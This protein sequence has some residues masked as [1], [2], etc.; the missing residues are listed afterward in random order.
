MAI[1]SNF[2]AIKPSLLLDF[3]NTKQLDPR[4]T[5]TRASTATFYDGVTTAKAEQNLLTYSQD[6]ANA[7]WTLYYGT[8]T[9]NS[10]VAPDGTTTA[11]TL[12]PSGQYASVVQN[13]ATIVGQQY[14]YS[15]WVKRATGS[16]VMSLYNAATGTDILSFTPTASWVRYSATFTATTALDA[17]YIQDRNASGWTAW[18]MWGAQLEQR[19][20]VTA[21]TATT[22]QAITNFIPVLQTAASGVARFDNNP[23]TGESLGLLI[24]ESR[25]NLVT[26]SEQ[27]DNAA[28]TKTNVSITANTIIAPDGT[29]TGDKIVENTSTTNHQLYSAFSTS[30]QSYTWSVYAKAG[31]RQY[32]SLGFSGSSVRYAWFDLVAGTTSGASNCTSAIT[33]V[34]NGFYRCSI[35][36]TALAETTFA[37]MFLG[38]SA[39]GY[40]PSYTGNGYSGIYIWGAQL[41][42]GAFATSYIPTVASTVTRA[43]DAASM[44]GTNFTSWYSQ[45]AGTI[46]V[47]YVGNPN[48]TSA[49]NQ[50]I[51]IFGPGTYNAANSNM[52]IINPAGLTVVT[53]LSGT[54]TSFS[55]TPRV[56]AGRFATSYSPTTVSAVVNNGTV[57][58]GSTGPSTGGITSLTFGITPS[59]IPSMNGS[60]KKF[61]FYPIAVTSAQ[62]QAL[63]S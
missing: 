49:A 51:Y 54:T 3:A 7:N 34:G 55:A 25:T 60:I 53:N 11:D 6:F 41:E 35:T 62:L 1:Q 36:A 27:F 18:D 50:G 31:E 48:V 14:T 37:Q 29:L 10:V 23:T 17:I 61:A 21:Y 19:S 52:G 13:A 56:V 43:A 12:T 28:W 26:Y 39:S 63:T 47:D 46:F 15:V 33:P 38:T 30:A 42:V 32:L 57:A 44:T 9:V 5:F 58:T 4:I 8:L 16:N 20:A 59:P 24:E 40:A 22:T 45:G 2:P